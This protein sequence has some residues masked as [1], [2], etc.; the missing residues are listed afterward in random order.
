MV[1]TETT[2]MPLHLFFECPIAEL[3]LKKTLKTGYTKPTIWN[4]HASRHASTDGKQ[5][6]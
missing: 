5:Y 3:L 1:R 4:T 6:N 2:E